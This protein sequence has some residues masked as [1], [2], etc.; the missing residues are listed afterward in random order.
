MLSDYYIVPIK[1]LYV[2]SKSFNSKNSILRINIV[3]IITSDLE[4]V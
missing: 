1:Y 2:S 3:K 4:N